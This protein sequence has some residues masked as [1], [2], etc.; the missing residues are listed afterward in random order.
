MTKS[1]M[2]KAM[3]SAIAK[4]KSKAM[5]ATPKKPAS[6][7]KGK[8][9]AGAEEGATPTKTAAPQAKAK[10]DGAKRQRTRKGKV[11]AATVEPQAPTQP[12][13]PMAG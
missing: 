13:E 8:R 5:K 7:V 11:Q 4:A 12:V 3:K 10:E 9:G 6:G 2:K 1:L